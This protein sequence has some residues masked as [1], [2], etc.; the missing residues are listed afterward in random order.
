MKLTR[1]LVIAI[2]LGIFLVLGIHAWL[3]I[4]ADSDV[5]RSDVRRDHEVLGKSI[6][7]L[8]E[9]LWET[10][11]SERA[12]EAVEHQNR[13]SSH[14]QIRLVEPGT[15][16]ADAPVR[17][18]LFPSNGHHATHHVIR[19]GGH[20]AMLTYVPI[21]V[22]GRRAA[23]ELY[24]PLQGELEAQHHSLLRTATTTGLL[25]LVCVAITVGFGIVFVARPLARITRR[26]V[27]VGEGH[28]DGRI[29]LTQNDEVRDLAVAFERMVDRLRESR[30]TEAAAVADRIA[31]LEQLRHADR[32]KTIGEIASAV[33]HELGTP[34]NVV[35][36]RGSMIASGEVTESRMR[37]LGAVVV[38]QVDRMSV[39][40]RQLLEYARRDP[41]KRSPLAVDPVV[42]YVVRMLAPVAERKSVSL[43][44]TPSHALLRC[45]LDSA[46]IQHALINIVVN[47]ID[48][49]STG[50]TVAV[51][52]TTTETRVGIVVRDNGQG[53]ADADLPRVL[54]PFFTTKRTGEGTGLGLAIAAEIVREHDGEVLIASVVG[55]GT[56]V[57][58][59]LPRLPNAAT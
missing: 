9:M 53:I 6:V 48:A 41:S 58:V 12:L 10:D 23:L 2:G 35:R 13:R 57:T 4:S 5:Y 30:A 43:T 32:L 47:A 49:V 24:E 36:A 22:P 8:V 59:T 20:N 29:D 31:A 1:N 54:E 51:S 56:T 50:G 21:V 42:Q 26:A 14:V 11:G 37:T 18:D 28:L 55:E 34:L 38:E 44:Y 15:T 17:A 45:T 52:V 46:E 40:I 3:R 39:I 7:T 25:L 16:P 27:E 19:H 33:A